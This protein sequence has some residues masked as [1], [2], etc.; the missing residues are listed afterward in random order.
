M[1]G[2]LILAAR[3]WL[4][5]NNTIR[6]GYENLVREIPVAYA[7]GTE[8]NRFT[9][10]S[11][12]DLLN[13]D[14]TAHYRVSSTINLSSISGQLPLGELRGSIVG[15]SEYAGL[16]GLNITTGISEDNITLSQT[17]SKTSN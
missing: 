13:M 9:L 4:N 12:D 7:N 10:D 11:A 5:D 17:T 1:S 14:L 16:T 3:D 2:T 8:L 15:A 6:S